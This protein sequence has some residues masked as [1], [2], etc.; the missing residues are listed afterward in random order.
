MTKQEVDPHGHLAQVHPDLAKVIRVA[1][2]APKA[3]VVVYGIRTEAAEAQAVASGHSQ[4]MHSR[5][6]PQ[7][8]QHELS[9]AVD[10]C[11]LGGHGA[12][13]WTV[14]DTSGGAFGEVARQIQHAADAL[15]IP[16]EWGGATVGAWEPG[17]VSTYHDWGHFQLPW[18]QYP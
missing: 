14:A 4:T 17:V 6:L 18:A 12:L 5:H 13:D 16:I 15:G 11:V 9:C 8:G 1:A 3:F 7:P 2:Q 10:V